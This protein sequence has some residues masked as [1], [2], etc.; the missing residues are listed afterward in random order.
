MQVNMSFVPWLYIQYMHIVYVYIRCTSYCCL[1]HSA[2]YLVGWL[3]E[4]AVSIVAGKA[5]VEES[6]TLLVPGAICHVRSR[7]EGVGAK[8]IASGK[9]TCF[10]TRPLQCLRDVP[11]RLIF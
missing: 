3:E 4:E 11:Q 10:K 5:V 1:V 6:D 8:V 7:G 2:F 9:L